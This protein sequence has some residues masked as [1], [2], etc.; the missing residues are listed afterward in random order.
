MTNLL[1]F[2]VHIL[3]FFL[4]FKC[5]C[6]ALGI[7]FVAGAYMSLGPLLNSIAESRASSLVTN[8]GGCKSNNLKPDAAFPGLPAYQRRIRHDIN[9]LLSLLNGD[10][11]KAWILV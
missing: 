2:I 3:N 8:N 4:R 11:G 7:H 10:M 9:I 5:H 1:L 6:S